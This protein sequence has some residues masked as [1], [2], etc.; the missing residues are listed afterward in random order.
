MHQLIINADDYGYTK[1]VS[2]GILEAYRNGIVTST[3]AISVSEDFA[4][5]MTLA[6]QFPNFPIGIHLALTV[7]QCR[8]ILGSEVPSLTQE[9]GEFWHLSDFLDHI[10]YKEV[11]KEW[12]AQIQTF[13]KTGRK[14]SHLDSHHNVH[15]LS[16]ELLQIALKL[17][18][19]YQLPLRNATEYAPKKDFQSLYRDIPTTK[20]LYSN[21]YGEKVSLETLEAIA[22]DILKSDSGVYEMNCHPAFIDKNLIS[23]TSYLDER[24]LELEI[25]CSKE[26]KELWAKK[27][28]ELINFT[29]L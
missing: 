25:L 24:I 7:R 14:A 23:K 4:Y 3:T 26:A 19:K 28:I 18:Q 22:D 8:P 27:N 9:N 11:E 5:S 1:G 21:F 15:C 13:L 10:D 17:A 6:E 20:R 16:E 12:D 2:Y 29:F